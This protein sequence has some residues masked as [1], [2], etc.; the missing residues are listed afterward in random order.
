MDLGGGIEGVGQTKRLIAGVS[1]SGARPNP[2]PR[3]AVGLAVLALAIAAGCGGTDE[4]G[5]AGAMAEKA[6]TPACSPSGTTLRVLTTAKR[7]HTFT[8]PQ[9][10]PERVTC[11]AAPADTP[12]KIEYRNDDTSSHGLHNIEILDGDESL[13]KGIQIYHTTHTYDVPALP[14]GI[15][16]FLCSQ[17][18]ELMD[19]AFV[20]E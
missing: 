6:T 20:V 11:L 18:L 19:G 10:A 1:S 5:D 9:L 15:Y 16:K 14:A 3:K 8:T 12:F 17:H 4:G 7:T 2:I 13:F